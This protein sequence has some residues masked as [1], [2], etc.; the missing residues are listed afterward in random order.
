MTG[1]SETRPISAHLKDELVSNEPEPVIAYV[2]LN[3]DHFVSL[4]AEVTCRSHI[5][6]PIRIGIGGRQTR[7]PIDLGGRVLVERQ[8]SKPSSP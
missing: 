2:A 3:M 5:V 6:P 4:P 7:P 8:G 1:L